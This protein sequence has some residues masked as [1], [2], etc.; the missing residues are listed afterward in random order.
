MT[1]K[2]QVIDLIETLYKT[3]DATLQQAVAKAQGLMTG[4]AIE[5][6]RLYG[7]ISESNEVLDFQ[8]IEPVKKQPEHEAELI[9][10]NGGAK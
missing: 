1:V 7:Q 5:L 2:E 10:L 6:G 3:V 8:L 9:I 4:Y